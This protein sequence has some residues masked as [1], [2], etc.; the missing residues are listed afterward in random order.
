[1]PERR[2]RRAAKKVREKFQQVPDLFQQIRDL[3]CRGAAAVSRAQ[4]EKSVHGY[5]REC[6]KF[7]P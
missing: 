3:L 6:V 7:A 4:A 5:W 1:M 2:R